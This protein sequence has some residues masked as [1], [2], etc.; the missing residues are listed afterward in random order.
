[1]RTVTRHEVEYMI[2]GK[3]RLYKGYFSL[4]QECDYKLDRL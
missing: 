3:K 2:V 1:M 4:S